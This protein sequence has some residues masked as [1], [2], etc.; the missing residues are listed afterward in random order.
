MSHRF[1]RRLC[2]GACVAL[3]LGFV[4]WVGV[5]EEQSPQR[6]FDVTVAIIASP[7]QIIA[8]SPVSWTWD[9]RAPVGAMAS[10]SGIRWGAIAHPGE[11]TA[12]VTPERSGYPKVL[13][14]ESAAPVA[15]PMRWTKVGTL[16]LPGT[17]SLRAYAVV[18]GVPY[19]SPEYGVTVE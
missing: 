10:R 13:V 16:P 2:I 8:E 11:W 14:E 18:D 9:V 19:W 6:R 17:Y 1:W 3:V 12:E 5:R 7:A 15:L 4:V